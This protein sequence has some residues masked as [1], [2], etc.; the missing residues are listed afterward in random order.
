M[1]YIWRVQ[2]VEMHTF[3]KTHGAHLVMARGLALYAITRYWDE[4]LLQSCF[5]QI[6]VRLDIKNTYE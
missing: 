3:G 1:G 5:Y 2:M 4:E 6:V